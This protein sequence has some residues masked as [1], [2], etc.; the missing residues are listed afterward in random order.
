MH[1]YTYV[2]GFS[3]CKEIDY[4][5]WEL[6]F[7]DDFD[8]TI[9]NREKWYTCIDGWNREHGDDELQYYLDENIIIRNGILELTAKREPDY[10]NVW[11]FNEDGS[12]YITTKYF[13]YTSGWI[14]TKTNFQYGLFEVR[15]KIP[16]GQGFWPAF[17]LFGNGEEIDVFEFESNKHNTPITTIHKW[18]DDGNNDYCPESW[19][20]NTSFADDY[21]TFSL[22]WDEYRL[23]FRVDGDITRSI[24]Y[25][26]SYNINGQL[27]PHYCD[28]IPPGFYF[29]NNIFPNNPQSIILNLAIPDN[30]SSFGPPPNSQTIFPSS[31]DIDYVRVYK[32]NNNNKDISICDY[33]SSMTNYYTGNAISV[34]GN[35]DISISNNEH[36]ELIA[37][38]EIIL[39]DGFEAKE[40][41]NFK[42]RITPISKKSISYSQDNDN[43]HEIEYLYKH[44]IVTANKSELF[45]IF[46]NPCKSNFY[47]KLHHAL[48]SYHEIQIYD[49]FGN[50]M[51]TIN[52]I[53]KQIYSFNIDKAGIYI[54]RCTTNNNTDTK[55]LIIQ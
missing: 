18:Y 14:Q 16:E 26:N 52:H 46:P 39:K 25:V 6:I 40:G 45:D 19:D 34:G 48:D 50:L 12:G 13:E 5:E 32:K 55:R 4:G 27:D 9:I 49:M 29:L 20:S 51:Y 30:N 43:S 10:Y 7:E 23:V 31:L 28:N 2:T 44:E 35:C 22:E 53:T 41:S 38:K 37:C 33:D 3:Q 17:W 1:T 8:N 42:A 11:R 54:V 24:Y 47:I 15:C 36:L 21:H